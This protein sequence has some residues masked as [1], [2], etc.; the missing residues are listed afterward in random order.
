[1]EEK[2]QNILGKLRDIYVEKRLDLLKQSYGEW[3]R[4]Q[5]D[6]LK[7]LEVNKDL[8]EIDEEVEKLARMR[9]GIESRVMN[10]VGYKV[11]FNEFVDEAEKK[12]AEDYLETFSAIRRYKQDEKKQYEIVKQFSKKRMF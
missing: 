10:G 7:A 2:K 3:Q 9:Q 11:L 12:L 4:T 6:F 1:M 8:R 5:D